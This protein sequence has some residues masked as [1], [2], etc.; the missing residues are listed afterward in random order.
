MMHSHN[1]KSVSPD[2]C[3]PEGGN[4]S[5]VNPAEFGAEACLLQ[6]PR[7]KHSPKRP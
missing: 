5:G 3:S 2:R 1:A 4:L 6:D 7:L